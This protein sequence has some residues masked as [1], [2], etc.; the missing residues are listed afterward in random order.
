VIY[1]LLDILEKAQGIRT[2]ACFIIVV[3]LASVG[4]FVKVIAPD[5]YLD[6]MK[7]IFGIYVGARGIYKVT[8]VAKLKANA[9]H[10]PVD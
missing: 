6:F 5:P 9:E 1:V 7:W 8:E 4:L 2:T 10:K 3:A